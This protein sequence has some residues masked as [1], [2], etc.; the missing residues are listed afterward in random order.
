MR[1][2]DIEGAR[3]ILGMPLGRAERGHANARASVRRLVGVITLA[4]IQDGLVDP[5]TLET[6]SVA[7]TTDD[8]F[9][10]REG[11]VVMGLTKPFSVALVT[12]D[13]TGLLVPSSCC[14]IRLDEEARGRLDPAFLAGYLMLPAVNDLLGSRAGGARLNTLSVRTVAELELPDLH[15]DAQRKLGRQALAQLE[16][17]RRRRELDAI[18]RQ[19][20]QASFADALCP[21]RGVVPHE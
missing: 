12:P 20:V 14:V 8:S 4:A 10:T 3:V 15:A 5:D 17:S 16:I 21:G 1:L 19:I 11:D 2:C 7:A 18:D 6:K 13:A 9:F